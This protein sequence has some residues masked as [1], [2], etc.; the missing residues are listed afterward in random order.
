MPAKPTTS[1]AAHNISRPVRLRPPRTP[2]RRDA[3]TFSAIFPAIL[4]PLLSVRLIA[5]RKFR[6]E[7]VCVEPSTTVDVS[8]LGAGGHLSISASQGRF[9]VE[10]TR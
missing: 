2:P 3:T 5:G 7:I 6:V 4:R 10:S 9:K 1:A 8:L